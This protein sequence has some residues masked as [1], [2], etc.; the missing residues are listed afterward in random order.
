MTRKKGKVMV[1]GTYPKR[2]DR[3]KMSAVPRDKIHAMTA[4]TLV[5]KGASSKDVSFPLNHSIA[6]KPMPLNVSSED[7]MRA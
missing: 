7:P 5:M 3:I 1:D 6:A 4:M 2:L